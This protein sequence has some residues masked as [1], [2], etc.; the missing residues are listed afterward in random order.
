MPWGLKRFHESGQAHFLTFSC[1]HRRPLFA[2][3]AVGRMPLVQF[4]CLL[5]ILWSAP[6]WGTQNALAAH[7]GRL[8][9][10]LAE[11]RNSPDDVPTQE[12]YIHLFPHT[13]KEFL[14]LFDVGQ[15]LYDGHDYIEALCS[16]AKGH[17]H[18]V[19]EL[20]VHLSKDA[21]YDADAPSYLQQATA[22]YG[23]RYTQHFV[24]LLKALPPSER[25]SLIGFLADIENHAQYPEYQ[26]IIDNLNAGGETA[27]AHQFEVARS[28]S[29]KRV[30]H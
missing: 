17:Q 3:W 8:R 20:L 28:E 9:Q 7:A 24:R 13:Y 29:I 2:E 22:E 6:A 1:Y 16:L 10:A 25:D 11:L 30:H 19:G 18:Q 14:Q 21:H 15:P 26:K 12:H 5:L 23:S 27:L 4:L